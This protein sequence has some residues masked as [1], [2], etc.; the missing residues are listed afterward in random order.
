MTKEPT[1]AV[2][3][4]GIALLAQV[5]SIV[6]PRVEVSFLEARDW[7]ALNQTSLSVFDVGPFRIIPVHHALSIRPDH[8]RCLMLSAGLAFGSGTHE[9]TQA[10]LLLMA[11]LAC[12]VR[13]RRLLDLGTGSGILAM[14]AALLWCRRVVAIDIDPVAVL[15][16][17]DNAARNA[18]GPRITFY[19]GAGVDPIRRQ[20]PYDLVFANI[21]SGAL[22][23]V[24]GDIR[25][26]VSQG[27]WLILSGILVLQ[28][29]QILCRYRAA[30]FRLRRRLVL[31][32]WVS[33]LL[34]RA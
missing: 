10:C 32:E 12:R 8:R 26:V 22:V 23:A 24:A 4:A 34:Q 28:E 3:E 17:R 6:A 25:R 20:R 11:S 18:L 31:G 15:V 2:L 16:A 33:F 1:V 7:L 21:L 9:T 14:A 5:Q 29:N 27:G 30:G 19:T 13:P